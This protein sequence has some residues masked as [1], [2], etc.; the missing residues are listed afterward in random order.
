[1][2]DTLP[3]PASRKEEYLAKAAGK[4]GVTLPE[5]ASREEIYLNAIAKKG[6]GGGG[7]SYTAG[8][9]IDITDDTIS[10]DTTTIQEKLTAGTNIT[11]SDNVI[12]ASGGGSITPV[13]TAGI[14][15]TDV[16][17]QNAT[18][19]LVYDS[20]TPYLGQKVK[21]GWNAATNGTESTSIGS[22]ASVSS[23]GAGGL[24]IGANANVTAQTGVAFAHGQ[25]STQG[26]FNVGTG[27]DWSSG[28]YNGT[29]YRLISGVYD[30][31]SSHDAATLGQLDGRVKQNAGA[32][33]TSTVG[34]VGQIL[35]DTT[36][37]KLYQ[38]TAVSGNTYTW[39]EVGAGGGGGGDTVYSGKTTSNS[40]DGGAV[41]IGPLNSSQQEL[42]D[43]TSTDNHYRYFWALPFDTTGQGN[44]GIPAD[45]SI[46]I[47]GKQTGTDSV[48][49]GY[50]NQASD[51]KSVVI[52]WQA[53]SNGFG[54]NIVIGNGGYAS[55]SNVILLGLNTE[56]Y[57]NN[58]VAL[59]A[60]SQV[61][62]AGE[63]NVGSRNTTY[64]YNNTNY[65]LI[66]GVHD[67]IDNHDAAT[68]GY[69]DAAAG[70]V[71]V[72][73]ATDMNY[74]DSGQGG[75]P[76]SVALWLLPTGLYSAMDLSNVGNVWVGINPNDNELV[77]SWGLILIQNDGA[78]NSAYINT[79]T[80]D[81]SGGTYTVDYDTGEI[82]SGI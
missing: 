30:G 67:P 23:T 24:A 43:P 60:Y 28:G 74:D 8:T 68:K 58:S 61:T 62:R 21:I 19:G 7:T 12:S 48:S 13:Q 73:S 32:P 82:T 76:N 53:K 6:G 72:L 49:I 66:G 64:G 65:R 26:E 63:V 55:N 9:G 52:G 31:Q 29:A 79:I 56:S 10:V 38:C 75:T 1:M 4:K 70:A 35:E 71:H 40:T 2:T 47:G 17:S 20:N 46:N 57:A 44:Y 34:T 33:T 80:P 42:A 15:T 5:P 3:D 41:Y 50:R 36:N 69:V 51:T 16:M 78:G 77:D 45:E 27:Y 54:N 18:T 37:G 14:S 59:G 22:R 39:S 11:I 25:A 81:L